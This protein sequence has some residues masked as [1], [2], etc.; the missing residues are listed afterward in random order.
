MI[1]FRPTEERVWRA[2]YSL[3]ADLRDA[4]EYTVHVDYAVMAALVSELSPMVS[5]QGPARTI[6]GLPIV[7]GHRLRRGAVVL[8]HEVEA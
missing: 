6:F 1:P 2:M 5:S 8:R 7:P 3:R 4:R